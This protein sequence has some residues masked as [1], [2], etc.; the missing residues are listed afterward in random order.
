M[1]YYISYKYVVNLGARMP[2]TN[3]NINKSTPIPLYFQLKEIILETIK[4]GSLK[5]GDLLPTEAEFESMFNISRTTVRQAMMELVKENILYRKKSK[6]T[7]VAK[8]KIKQENLMKIRAAHALITS[9]NVKPTTKVLEIGKTQADAGVAE[10]LG[11]PVGS[12]VVKMSRIRYAN[13]VPI[14][15]SD[16][17]VPPMCFDILNYNMEETGLYEF[18]DKNEETKPVRS[19]REIEAKIAGKH[20]SE[21]LKIK[22]GSAIQLVRSITYNKKNEVVDFTITKFVGDKNVFVVELNV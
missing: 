14:L 3:K 20:I 11:V 15:Y 17:Y 5:P 12:E 6:G 19:I 9:Q 4:E 21:L 18:M 7:F 16:T 22:R 2:F 1:L 10:H 8:P 13:N